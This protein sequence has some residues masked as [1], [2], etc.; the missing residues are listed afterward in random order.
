MQE[1]TD[2]IGNALAKEEAKAERLANRGRITLLVILTF[3]ALVNLRSVTHEANMMN[4]TVLAIGYLYGVMVLIWM[5][6]NGYHPIMKY[7]T[8]CLDIT[9]VFLLLFL[10]TKIEIP[11][12]ALKNYVFVILYPLI[13]LTA[14]RYDKKL[15]WTVGGLT[16]VLYGS[17][18]TYLCLSGSMTMTLGGYDRELFSQDVTYIGQATKL[19]ILFGF[20]A[21]I[22][23]LAQY[24]RRLIITLV[25]DESISRQKQ[26]QF[27]YELRIAAD[28]QQQFV[29]KSFPEIAG[30]TIYG[31]VEQGK[32]IGGDYC[33][34]IKLSESRLLVVIADVS[35]NG[36]PAALIMAEV[37]ASVHRLGQSET[38]L[39]YLVEQINSLLFR[40]TDKKYFVTFFVAEINT[41]KRIISYVNAGHPRPLVHVGN[42]IRLLK[43]G[44]I[45]LGLSLVLPNLATQVEEFQEGSSLVA[46]TDGLVEQFNANKEQFGEERLSSFVESNIGLETLRFAQH[47]LE[48]VK[49]FS[50]G[51]TF[52]DDVGLAIVKFEE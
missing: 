47:L 50:K 35:G 42:E 32:S 20:I 8:S 6:R 24:S 4:F 25:R 26:E 7:I 15:T 1:L 37:R 39:E 22:A 29:P 27:E 52:D 41:E 14:F 43:K 16:M 28:V 19:I 12:V 11:S 3:L 13:G 21:L 23:Y 33:D 38:R 17:L 51:K 2:R 10:Y 46:Y 49:S 45:P 5:R 18:I 31:I 40:S 9:M 34:F 48:Q 30:L 36:I 44:T